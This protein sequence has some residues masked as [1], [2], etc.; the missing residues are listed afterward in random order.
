MKPGTTRGLRTRWALLALS[1]LTV[2]TLEE[3][4]AQQPPAPRQIQLV[5]PFSPGG[6]T[7][8][9]ARVIGPRLSARLGLPIVVD[10]KPGAGGMLGADYLSRAPADGSVLMLT[11][12]DLSTGA[13]VQKSLPF[14]AEKGVTAVAMLATGPMVVAVNGTSPFRTLEQ[15]LA[16]ARQN[17]GQINYGSAGIGSLHHL[18]GEL[19]ASMAKVDMTHVPYKGSAPAVQDLVAAR[20]QTMIASFPA[21]LAQVKADRLRILAVTTPSRARFAPDL[22]TV[23]SVVPGYQVEIW[24]GVFAPGA[25]PQPVLDRLNAELRAVVA[26]PD[27]RD[28]LEREGAEPTAMTAPEAQSFYLGDIEKWRGIA[29]MRRISLD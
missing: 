10:N 26:A 3:V 12:S 27:M 4:S 16:A 17:P 7:D 25:T 21:T 22:A 6:S 13:A 11:A 28:T 9:M 24:W 20:I 15:L 18:S 1:V 8:L 29:R 14:D 2:V 19:F 5:V 23:A